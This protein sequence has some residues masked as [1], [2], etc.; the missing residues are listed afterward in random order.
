MEQI[1]ALLM[2][3][4]PRQTNLARIR[5]LHRLSQS[6]LSHASGVGL[7]SIQAYEQRVNSINRAS[8]LTLSRLSAVLNCSIE[9]LL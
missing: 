8:G 6:D 5:S 7:K 1:D 2:E 3:A 4:I 9:S